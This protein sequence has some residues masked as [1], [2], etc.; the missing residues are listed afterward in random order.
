MVQFALVYYMLIKLVAIL[1]LSLNQL[2][3][4]SYYIYFPHFIIV[5]CE[6][7]SIPFNELSMDEFGFIINFEL[8][9]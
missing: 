4:I 5:Q 1:T 7:T 2:F 8:I 9:W 6:L 3:I